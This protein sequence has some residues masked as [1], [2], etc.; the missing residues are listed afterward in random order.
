MGEERVKTEGTRMDMPGT[1]RQ[2]QQEAKVPNTMK[3]KFWG[4]SYCV[5]PQNIDDDEGICPWAIKMRHHM[6]CKMLF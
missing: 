6:I 4:K 5:W 2:N 1:K 3:R